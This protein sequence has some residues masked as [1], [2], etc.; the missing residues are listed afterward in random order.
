[1]I[2]DYAVLGRKG[3]GK[4]TLVEYMTEQLPAYEEYKVI[5]FADPLKEMTRSLFETIGFKGEVIEDM[6]EGDKKESQIP[7]FPL[8]TPRKI[9]QT[10]G[11]EW[12]RT[13]ISED[14]WGEIW[15][16]RYHNN[17]GATFC[18]DV[19]FENELTRVDDEGLYLVRVV[20]QDEDTSDGHTSEKIPV[21]CDCE[22]FVVNDKIPFTFDFDELDGTLD[23]I[24]R[25]ETL[26]VYRSTILKVPFK[27][28][29]DISY[30]EL[31]DK[32]SE[33]LREQEREASM[34]NWS[35]REARLNLADYRHRQNK[36]S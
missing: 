20:S 3:S 9:M 15:E 27:I 16:D 36:E 26:V 18:D 31:E 35:E 4:S 28:A 29:N 8:L 30:N 5:K 32:V 13:H 11:T 14:F 22:V 2:N 25:G 34:D 12:G 23:D 7:G 17:D 21:G 1:M 6:V 10:L 19:R 33:Y 24:S